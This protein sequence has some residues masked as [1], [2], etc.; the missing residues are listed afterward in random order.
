[1]EPIAWVFIIIVGIGAIVAAIGGIALLIACWWWL[2]PVIGALT[3]GAIGL[4]F[5]IGLNVVIW[6]IIRICNAFQKE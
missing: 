6:V 1:M 2:I 5:G 4:F 3:G